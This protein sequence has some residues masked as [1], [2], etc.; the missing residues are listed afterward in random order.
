MLIDVGASALRIKR[1]EQSKRGNSI[2]NA[3]L[4]GD[5]VKA[6]LDEHYK[7]IGFEYPGINEFEA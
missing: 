3:F 2:M 6:L 5:S 4:N 7:H 1:P